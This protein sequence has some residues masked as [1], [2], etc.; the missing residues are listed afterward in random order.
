MVARLF[1]TLLLL[2]TLSFAG[3]TDEVRQALEQ[4][5]FPAAQ[6][7]LQTYRAQQGLTPDYVEALS[8]MARS[9]LASHQLDQADKYAKQTDTLSRQLLAKRPLDAEPHLPTG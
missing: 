4:N 2:S 1:A 9:S 6:A 8:W 7:E 5:N 3:I